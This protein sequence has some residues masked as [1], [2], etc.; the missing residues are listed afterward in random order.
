MVVYDV[1]GDLENPRM[2][3]GFVAQVVYFRMNPDKRFLK[4][5]V[6]QGFIFHF[7]QDKPA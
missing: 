3:F 6:G 4:Q 2:N 7:I 1:S 5:I